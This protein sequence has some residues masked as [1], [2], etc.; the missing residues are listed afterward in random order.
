[1]GWTMYCNTTS[2]CN[3]AY[4]G[5]VTTSQC[6]Q[7]TYC[8]KDDCAHYDYL[9]QSFTTVSGDS[10]SLSFYIRPNTSPAP[11]VVYVTLI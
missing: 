7:G 6:Q 3:G 4:Y 2:N 8:Y 5:Q 1:M 11:Q 10:Y 9:T